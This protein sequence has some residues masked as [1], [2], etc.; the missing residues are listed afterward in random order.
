MISETEPCLATDPELAD[1]LAELFS[2]E[3][4]HLWPELGTT[5]ADFE[6]ML[7]AEFWEIGASG[8]R[9]SRAHALDVLEKRCALSQ[10]D[11][12]ESTDYYCQRLA[13]DV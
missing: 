12:W 5:R 8:R 10:H 9:W 11:L 6:Q 1:I 7:A 4:I 3:R 2:R 13:E